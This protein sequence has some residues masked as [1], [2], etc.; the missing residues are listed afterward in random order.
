MPRSPSAACFGFETFSLYALAFFFK[1]SANSLFFA[2][3]VLDDDDERMLA[4]HH[5]AGKNER[6]TSLR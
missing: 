2:L 4:K 5:N 6:T 3:L 1:N